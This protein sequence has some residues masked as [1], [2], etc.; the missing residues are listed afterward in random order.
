MLALQTEHQLG[1]KDV[2]LAVQ[3]A[4]SPGDVALLRYELVDHGL[5][6]TVGERNEVDDVIHRG[7]L[8]VEL[9]EG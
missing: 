3:D 4:P 5:E 1:A 6:L 9:K 7:F 8:P 2:D